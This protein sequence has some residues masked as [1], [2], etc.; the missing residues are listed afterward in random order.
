MVT[1]SEGFIGRH[2]TKRLSESGHEVLGLSRRR[3][4]RL[5]LP[6]YSYTSLDLTDRGALASYLEKT[7]YDWV[8]HLAGLTTHEELTRN[9]GKALQMNLEGLHNVLDAFVRSDA[10]RFLFAS[11]GKVYGRIESLPT[12]E[13]HPTAPYN[14][15]GRLKLIAEMIIDFY[16]CDSEKQFVTLRIF[17]VYGPEQRSYFL[18]PTILSQLRD[19]AGEATLGSIDDRRDYVYIDDVVEAIVTCLESR[20]GGGLHVYNVGSGRSYSA[21]DIVAKIGCILGR[22]IRIRVDE[23]RVR[24]DECP[25]EYA[26]TRRIAPLGWRPRVDLKEGLERTI[27]AFGGL[28]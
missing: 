1:G 24:R 5:R 17:N 4:S 3:S 11:T 21:R 26:D 15:L 22:R 2:L 23:R 16:A 7:E 10:T 19:G 6:G 8:V 25:E 18:I 27:A 9:R 13:D 20:L 14:V 28:E 12:A